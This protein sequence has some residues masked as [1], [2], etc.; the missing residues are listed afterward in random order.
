MTEILKITLVVENIGGLG[1]KTTKREGKLG[2]KFP[3]KLM[4]QEF[5]QIN[6]KVQGE[7]K[8]LKINLD[9]ENFGGLGVKTAKK[10]GKLG[11]K[12]A[13]QFMCPES[14]QNDGMRTRHQH[15][16]WKLTSLLKMLVV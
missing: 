4:P 16:V 2:A 5:N 1:V 14:Y 13:W 7:K 12:F 10:Q 8:I 15:K 9:V 6:R 11:A 3:W